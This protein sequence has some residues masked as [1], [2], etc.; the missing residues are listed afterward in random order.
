MSAGGTTDD[1]GMSTY[2][3]KY[4][5]YRGSFSL[6]LLLGPRARKRTGEDL[7]IQKELTGSVKNAKRGKREEVDDDDDSEDLATKVV[8]IQYYDR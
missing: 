6:N 8:I 2:F 3:L 1:G 5:N 7:E 4:E